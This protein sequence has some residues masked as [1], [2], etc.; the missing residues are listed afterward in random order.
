MQNLSSLERETLKA[1][2][3]KERDKRICDR[4]KAVLL[5]DEGWTYRQIANALL[6]SD[7]AV[8]QHILDFQAEHKLKPENGGSDGKLN[9]QQT[10]ALL[11]H[12]RNH[13]YLYVK[14]IVAY[15]KAIFGIEYTVPGM[16]NW[17]HQHGF[18]YK[19]PAIVPG[20][21]NSEL[22]QQWIQEYE[23]LRTKLS[24]TE[25][26]CFIDGVHPTHNTKLAY[27]WIQRGERKEI[28]TNTGRQRLNLCGAF[29]VVLKKVLVQEDLSL[30]A[31]STIIFLKSL[32]AAYPE[33]SKVHVFCDN[34]RYYKNKE[35][36]AYLIHSKIEMHFLPPYSPNLN[37]IERLWKL[38]HENVLNNKYYEKFSEFK[39]AVL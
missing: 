24:S 15:V 17:L 14:D 10:E 33:K 13:T 18:A 30:N 6:L 34:A 2:H 28:P 11:T 1:K 22:Q 23:A 12:L 9:C 20:K 26:I 32:E 27:G 29:D 25:T 16:T 37:F 8:R 39:E 35:V 5:F 4:I 19:K 21:A 36:T 38:L 3:K 31:Q 7:E